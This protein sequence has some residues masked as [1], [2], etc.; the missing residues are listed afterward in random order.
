MSEELLI[1]HCSPTL[2]GIKTGGPAPGP[3]A[4]DDLVHEIAFAKEFIQQQ[5]KFGAHAVIDMQ[6]QAPGG[7][8]QFPAARK[9][10]AH[11]F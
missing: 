9:D 11:P 4:P 10:G 2:A 6:I 5:A 1:R 7:T 8:K 3:V